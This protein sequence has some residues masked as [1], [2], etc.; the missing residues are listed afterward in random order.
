MALLFQWLVR[1][2]AAAIVLSVLAILLVYYLA[3]RSLPNYS[4]TITVDGI[5]A[6]IEIV[7]DNANVPHILA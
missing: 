4:A 5:N 6:P 2:T 1:L 3:S 7:R